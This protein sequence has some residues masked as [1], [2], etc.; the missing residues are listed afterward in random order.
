MTYDTPEELLAATGGL[1]ADGNP[2]DCHA[3][4]RALAGAPA[5]RIFAADRITPAGEIRLAPG[6]SAIY[7]DGEAFS[8]LSPEDIGDLLNQT[9]ALPI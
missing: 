5:V 8:F 3:L 9:P 6:G 2:A 7:F 4:W 1:D